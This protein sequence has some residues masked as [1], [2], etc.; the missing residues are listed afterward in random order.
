M[1]KHTPGPWLGMLGKLVSAAANRD[2]SAW[3]QSE[4]VAAAH[5]ELFNEMR[6]MDEVQAGLLEAL[7]EAEHWVSEFVSQM[8]AYTVSDK[9]SE[10]AARIRAAIAKARGES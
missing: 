8:S 4:Q 7:I 9:A 1:S 2:A 3:E 5:T 10:S 6:R